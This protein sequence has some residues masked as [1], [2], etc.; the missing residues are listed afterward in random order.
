MSVRGGRKARRLCVAGAIVLL[1][2]V[3]IFPIAP[4][5][6]S[7]DA[8]WGPV[9][10]ANPTSGWAA[11]IPLVVENKY[12]FKLE[13]PF[14]A[15]EVDFSKLLVEAGWTNATFNGALGSRG[16]TLDIDSIRVVPYHSGFV[17]GPVDGP[18]TKPIAHR[19]YPAM[20]E[21]K[22]RRFDP[23][24]AH[25]TVL[26]QIPSDL[27]PGEK[28][29]YYIYASPL[30]YGD[31][32]APAF[33]PL[34]MGSVDAFLW[35]TRGNV[36]LG[37]E[38]QQEGQTT[39][40]NRILA[41]TPGQTTVKIY[42]YDGG[43]KLMPTTSTQPNPFTLFAEGERAIVVPSGKPFKIEADKPILV[44]GTGGVPLGGN[45]A[46]RAG[47]MPGVS[48]SFAD[49]RFDVFGAGRDDNVGAFVR[50]IKASPGSVTV[51]GPR[52]TITLTPASP[53]AG[54]RIPSG[55]WSQLTSPDGKFLVMLQQRAHGATPD[56]LPQYSYQIPSTTGGPSGKGFYG[57]AIND[58]G[59]VRVCPEANAS[60][61]IVHDSSK[62]QIFP[63]GTITNT[64]PARFTDQPFCEQVDVPRT[65]PTA[66]GAWYE[67]FSVEDDSGALAVPP[68][69]FRAFIGAGVRDTNPTENL[70]RPM[71]G[72]YGGLGGVDYYTYGDT[73]LF[74]HYNDTSVTVREERVKNGVTSIATY[75]KSLQR[76]TYVAL[77]KHAEGTGRFH[78]TS[79]KPI[80]AA[81]LE[82]TTY[83]QEDL[84]GVST[85][86]SAPYIR[87]VPG[88]P[89]LPS[90]TLGEL[91]FRGPL[92]DL[93]SPA[94]PNRQDFKTTGPGSKLEYRVDVLNLGRWIQG[95]RLDDTI[96][97][98]CATP[99]G[100]TVEGCSREVSLNG[101]SAERLNVVVTPPLEDVGQ[102][103]PIVIEARS[104]S[105][106]AVATFTLRVHVEIRYG[107]GLWF[108][109][110]GGR[111]TMDPPV[112]LAPGDTYRGTIVMKNTGSTQDR[113]TLRLEDPAEGWEHALLL[114]DEPVTSVT[115]DGGESV[116][117]TYRATAPNLEQGPQ[118]L[119]SLVARSESSALAADIVYPGTRIRPKIDLAMTLTPQTQLAAPNETVVFNITTHNKGNAIFSIFFRQDSVLPVGWTAT[120]STE[121]V[122]LNPNDTFVSQLRVTPAQGARAGDLASMKLNAEVD[123]GGGRVAGD[124]VS[125]V[126]VVRRV[127]N[128][129]TPPVA[130][131]EALPGA[132]LR[133]ALP[134]LNAGNGQVGVELL[135]GAVDAAL[136]L[137]NGD[138]RPVADWVVAL[139]ASDV[140]L[141]LNET[142]ELPLRIEVPSLT[143]PGLYNLTFTTRLSREAVQN[144]TVPVQVLALSRVELEGPARVEM[145]P[146][147]PITLAYVARNTGNVDGTFDL[148]AQAPAG[149]NATFSP[150][151]SLLAPGERMNVR[152]TLNATRDA[153]NG[154]YEVTLATA[155]EGATPTTSKLL[156]QIARPQLYLADV[157]HTGDLRVGE[158]II[159]TATVGNRGGI[160][161]DNVSVALVVDDRVVDRAT[162]SRIPIGGTGVATLSWVATQRG[163]DARVILDPEQEIELE[164]RDET[165]QG[166]EFGSRLGAPGP[167]ILVV[168]AAVALALAWRR[169]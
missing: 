85:I 149:W 63:E 120:L 134:I 153:A 112:G 50:V 52:D 88:R 117:L 19:F 162:L 8:W 78:I 166:V 146:G 15:A 143:P 131:A 136:L 148:T 108:D 147:R 9:D 156:V 154:P 113:F 145:T 35:G 70:T 67:F 61:R 114:H 73:G 165:Q 152:L 157:A 40:H 94:T 26:F 60:V 141:A 1:L 82:P 128:L 169:R 16:F 57:W 116:L 34:D 98:T 72:H 101:G 14:V 54:I 11:R 77:T 135:S 139:E 31:M 41:L 42:T 127:Y 155:S 93:V 125:A 55:Q 71:L 111:K 25:G 51:N 123:T 100:W 47:Y 87:N 107:V 140:T 5:Q 138:T 13:R 115:L 7:S 45:I 22:F 158:L 106:G 43:F 90:A 144:L 91:E 6:S 99:V 39:H 68:V 86:E 10:R 95:G 105:G 30:E 142:V 44:F 83:R 133:Y 132:T 18:T 74:G 137:P 12:D 36:Y 27:A 160:S 76:D 103:H 32:P 163:G 122:S 121:E 84:E 110:E 29:S 92:V 168:L 59:W 97:V 80:A 58:E 151:R 4:A 37:Y 150:P 62:V 119:V 164:T 161:A 159:V 65:A 64:P 2:L 104:K 66:G 48:G 167:G 46:D 126:V 124:E 20:L 79:T 53:S 118:N 28:R 24:A 21:G 109:V 130:D 129:T 96:T 3:P 89:M 102:T 56:P 75:A 23:A 33:D 69:P 17:A 49:D 81:S 38:P